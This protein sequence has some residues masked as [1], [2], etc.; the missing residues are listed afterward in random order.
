M[1]QIQFK[2]TSLKDLRAFPETVRSEAGFELREVQKGNEPTDWKPMSSIGAG[3]KEIRVKDKQGVFRVVYLVKY[4][5]RV[6]VL[7]AFQKKTQKTAKKDL[8]LAKQRLKLV[9]EDVKNG[10]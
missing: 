1:K 3:V 6:I 2:G 5:D 8:D 10:K 9:L 4:L 7:H